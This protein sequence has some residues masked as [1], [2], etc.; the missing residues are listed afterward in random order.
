MARLLKDKLPEWILNLTTGTEIERT[1]AQIEQL[2]ARLFDEYEPTQGPYPKFFHRIDSWLN[3]LLDEEEQKLLFQLV[4]HIFFLGPRELEILYRVAFNIQITTWIIEEA[5]LKLDDPYLS[6]RLVQASRRTWYCPITDSMRIN[7]F[8]HLNNIPG[9]NYRPDWRSLER[10]GDTGKV[11]DFIVSNGIDRI[12][13]LEDFVGSGSQIRAALQYVATLPNK[14]PVLI[15]PLILC[16]AGALMLTRFARAFSHLTFSPVIALRP[17]AFLSDK[18]SPNE[19]ALFSTVRPLLNKHYP[20]L[21]KGLD[22]SDRAK[23]YGPF[24]F[25]RTGGMVVM[26]TNCPDNTLPV[27]HCKSEAWSPLFPRASRI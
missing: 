20:L 21:L 11:D 3:S 10:L 18:A 23:M 24:G 6:S 17:Q 12:V 16:P 14:P 7:A 22:A 15:V 27:I 25:M 8:Y 9:I 1:N 13:L 5:K 2:A 4:P 19:P 26:W